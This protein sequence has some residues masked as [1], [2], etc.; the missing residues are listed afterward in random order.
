MILLMQAIKSKS[1]T[2]SNTAIIEDSG[3]EVSPI[4]SDNE[5]FLMKFI[6]KKNR[7]QRTRDKFWNLSYKKRL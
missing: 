5:D 1:S 6:L 4:A 7:A 3:T 2:D